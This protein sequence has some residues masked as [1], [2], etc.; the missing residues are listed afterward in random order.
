WLTSPSPG[1][2]HLGGGGLSSFGLDLFRNTGWTP[3][4]RWGRPGGGD[5]SKNS[6]Q[7]VNILGKRYRRLRAGIEACK[8]PRNCGAAHG[9]FKARPGVEGSRQIAAERVAGPD[10]VD[11]LDLVGRHGNR[12]LR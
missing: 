5:P 6:H 10:R 11:R 8:A 3:P 2:P 12:S 4:P 9:L 1:L 7:R